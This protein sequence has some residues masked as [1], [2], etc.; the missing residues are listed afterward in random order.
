ME[1]TLL[2]DTQAQGVLSMVLGGTL[3]PY[4]VASD[5][6]RHEASARRR[7]PRHFLINRVCRLAVPAI[8]LDAEMVGDVCEDL[9]RQ[10][11]VILAEGG[12]VYPAPLRIVALGGDFFRFVCA[13]PSAR[14]FATVKGE[15]TR[16]GA[17]RD[18]RPLEPI[19][20]VAEKLGGI[21]V[22][23]ETWAGLE[24]VPAA[25]G[26]WLRSLDARLAWAP[27]PAGS[28]EHEEP[29]EWSGLVLDQDE[30]RWRASGPA[31]LWRARHRWKRWV[32]AWS[33]GEPPCS[34]AF[35]TLYAD[36]G[37]RTVFAEALAAEKPFR[38][39]TKKSG[40]EVTIDISGWLP[41][42]EYRY[43]STC[44][45]Q[46]EATSRGSTW[47]TPAVRADAVVNTLKARLGLRMEQGQAT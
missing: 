8:A 20:A 40:A 39:L 24:R 2:T 7:T 34:Q 45:D 12:I 13:V 17:R 23:P 37:A 19:E 46:V 32:Y 1:L 41:L 11:D 4:N 18:C 14:L 31:R 10:G 9:E 16:R 47:T 26:D 27:E 15:W 28:L 21:L 43:L 22:T 44:A 42:A 38:A 35:V 25:D 29:L 30:P 36:E 3:E 6:V 5:L 33:A